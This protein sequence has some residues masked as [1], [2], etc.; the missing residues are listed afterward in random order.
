MALYILYMYLKLHLIIEKYHV[1][2][3][4]FL[5]DRSKDQLNKEALFD[6]D[7]NFL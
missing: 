4:F 6:R 1:I 5:V 2:K 3:C 7:Y